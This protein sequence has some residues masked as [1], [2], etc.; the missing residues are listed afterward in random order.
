MNISPE[1]EAWMKQAA[2]HFSDSS[3]EDEGD[4][5]INEVY[6][7]AVQA[8]KQVKHS[9][10]EQGTCTHCSITNLIPARALQKANSTDKLS[11]SISDSD[12]ESQVGDVLAPVLNS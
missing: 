10:F 6:L 8:L 9:C 4:T 5:A 12:P 3:D 7:Q 2:Y 11:T 1:D